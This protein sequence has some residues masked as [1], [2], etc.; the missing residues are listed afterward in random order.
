MTDRDMN[1]LWAYESLRLLS[2]EFTPDVLGRVPFRHRGLVLRHFTLPS[3][4][5]VRSVVFN[6][7]PKLVRPA[8]IVVVPRQEKLTEFSSYFSRGSSRV[9]HVYC[10]GVFNVETGLELGETSSEPWV[11]TDSEDDS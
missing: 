1:A 5:R 3:Q 2:G 8:C 7:F 10:Q 9:S 11:R 4:S 6:P